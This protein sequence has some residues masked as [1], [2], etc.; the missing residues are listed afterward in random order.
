MRAYFN[1]YNDSNINKTRR[2]SKPTVLTSE[3]KYMLFVQFVCANKCVPGNCDWVI[4]FE[5]LTGLNKL[6]LPRDWNNFTS[7]YQK[8]KH[9]MEAVTAWV[10]KTFTITNTILGNNVENSS[11]LTGI[12]TRLGET[13]WNGVALMSSNDK[14]NESRITMTDKR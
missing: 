8:W 5:H 10:Y 12:G 4:I 1:K 6:L 14:I 13:V 9:A 2:I 7:S 11:S 3:D